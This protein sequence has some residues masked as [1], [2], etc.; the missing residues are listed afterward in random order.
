M[1]RAKFD[2]SGYDPKKFR[3]QKMPSPER[4]IIKIEEDDMEIF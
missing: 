1:S 3:K 4:K 2:F